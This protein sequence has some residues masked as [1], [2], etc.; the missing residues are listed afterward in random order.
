MSVDRHATSFNPIYGSGGTISYTGT[1]GNSGNLPQG[2]AGVYVTCSTDA[3][4]R[5]GIAPTAV[6]SDFFC[7]A[8]T[9]V[10]VPAMDYTGGPLQLSVVRDAASGSARYSPVT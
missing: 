10:F 9:P 1:A 2:I 3:W 6:T 4:A 8:G 7:P 5:L